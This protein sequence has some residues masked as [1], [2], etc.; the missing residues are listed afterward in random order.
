MAKDYYKVL[1]VDKGASP[2]EIKKAFRSLAHKYHPDKGGDPERF[3]E[4]NEANQI[5]SDA[6]K[7]AQYDQYGSAAFDAGGPFSGGG[8]AQGQGP[9][10]GFGQNVDFEDLG[11]M[12]GDIFGMGRRGAS[13][14][15]DERGEDISVD[16]TITLQDSSRGVDR[17]IA[18][19]KIVRCS[20]CSGS[21]GE[22]G[23]T[24]NTCET[25]R[26]VGQV[27]GSQ[28]TIFGVMQTQHTCT[29]C[30]GT[31]KTFSKRCKECTGTGVHKKEH[32]LTV[33]IPAGIDEGETLR[34]AHEGNAG[35]HGMPAG[36][37]Y[38][39]I[40]VKFDLRFKRL[41]NDILV[42][43]EIGFTKAALGGEV[44]TDSIEGPITI[45]I[46]SGTQSG[47]ILRVRGKGM[48][49]VRK[50]GSKGD[51]L[52]EVIVTTPKKLSKEQR[53]LLEQADLQ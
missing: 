44:Q 10:G 8:Q 17:E 38:I 50:S 11:D 35:M 34:V 39:R 45:T 33:S 37:L 19:Y 12:F 9:F 14:T 52:V 2:E 47:Q 29:T 4:V 40:H 6:T 53:R 20:H 36:D 31:G 7:R 43:K 5:L 16:L 22:P 26:G 1:G 30:S 13:R 21:G 42:R 49:Y 32:R 51:L 15:H 23:A 24:Q 18:L 46:P 41:E 3:K 28:R 48:P 27:V 25:C